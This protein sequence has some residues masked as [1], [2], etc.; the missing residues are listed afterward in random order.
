[1]KQHQHIHD[2]NDS[3]ESI[4]CKEFYFISNIYVC[5]NPILCLS[6]HVHVCSDEISYV[7]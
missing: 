3:S 2:E 7:L 6:N 4:I 1:M 5:V